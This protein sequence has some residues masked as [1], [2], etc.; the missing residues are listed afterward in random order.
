MTVGTEIILQMV[1]RDGRKPQYTFT[2][3]RKIAEANGLYKG[4]VLLLSTEG[5]KL[6]IRPRTTT[7]TGD[8]S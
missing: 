1:E 5:D 8:D 4:Q 7:V 2:I 3:P 6:I